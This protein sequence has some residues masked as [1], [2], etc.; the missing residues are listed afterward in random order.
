MKYNIAIVEDEP[1]YREQLCSFVE[2]FA[3]EQN[4]DIQTICFKDGI[5]LVDGYT[6][7]YDLIFLDI[8]MPLLDGMT[9][10]EKI[11][12]LDEEVLLIFVTNLAQYAIRGYGVQALDYVLKPIT[13][14]AF[15]MKMQ[16][17]CQ[18]IGKRKQQFVLLNGENGTAR[19]RESDIYY[20]EVTDHLLTYHTAT[21]NYRIFGTMKETEKKL[22]DTFVR[23][24]HGYLVNLLHV[25]GFSDDMVTVHDEKAAVSLKISRSKKKEFVQKLTQYYQT[26]GN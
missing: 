7:Q 5:D 11:R 10:A 15:F 13:Y 3:K 9:A 2:R 4:L 1:K 17:A 26:G 12:K 8:E 19:V 16:R 25:E 6:A 24:N 20:V 22:S 23:I 18:I 21:G 14:P